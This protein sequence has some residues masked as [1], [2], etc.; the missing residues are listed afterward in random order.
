M[1]IKKEEQEEVQVVQNETFFGFNADGDAHDDGLDFD[2]EDDFDGDDFDGDD[3]F[4][5]ARGKRRPPRPP[6]Q[7]PPKMAARRMAPPVV[8]TP[9]VD[10]P[11]TTSVPET[12]TPKSEGVMG[13]IKKYKWLLLAGG[14]AAFL[15]LTPQGKKLIGKQ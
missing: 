1:K 11:V 14:I 7:A 15:F 8:D 13:A 10:T 3:N 12:E 9:V 2:G 6:R 4:S 5:N